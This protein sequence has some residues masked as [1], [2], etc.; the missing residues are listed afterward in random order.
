[1][2]EQRRCDFCGR[3]ND[4]LSEPQDSSNKLTLDAD[5]LWVCQECGRKLVTHA[6]G[7]QTIPDLETP[8]HSLVGQNAGAI[9]RTLALPFEPP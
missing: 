8:L 1:M 2:S 5:N 7:Q 9:C 4:I 3:P 6:E